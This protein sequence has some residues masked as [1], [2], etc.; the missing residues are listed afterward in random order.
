MQIPTPLIAA[1][2]LL[3]LLLLWFA[4]RGRDSRRDL[5]SPPSLPDHVHP[6]P[7]PTDQF[8]SQTGPQPLA[9]EL[10]A[11]LRELVLQRRKI[12]AIKRLREARPMSLRAAKEWVERL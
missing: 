9:A 3:F 6:P 12:E 7:P 5:V 2:A 8:S 11:E 1:A 10:E 4:F